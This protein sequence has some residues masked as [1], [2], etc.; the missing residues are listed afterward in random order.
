M[1]VDESWFLAAHEK[2]PK[3]TPGVGCCPFAPRKRIAVKS[4]ALLLAVESVPGWGKFRTFSQASRANTKGGHAISRKRIAR[5]DFS[6]LAPRRAAPR[7]VGALQPVPRRDRQG[8]A[9]APWSFPRI[10]KHG[11]SGAPHW[12]VEG[13]KQQPRSRKKE[14]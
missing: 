6:R 13:C 14:Q 11:F 9:A 3:R 1:D 4:V 8:R 2:G 10:C 12:L 5:V 7:G